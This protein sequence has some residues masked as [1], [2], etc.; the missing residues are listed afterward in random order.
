[1]EKHIDRDVLEHERSLCRQR[2]EA[3]DL[4]AFEP[5]PT[6]LAND[7]RPVKHAR[8]D[9]LEDHVGWGSLAQHADALFP[10]QDSTPS[11]PITLELDYE[12]DVE[13]KPRRHRFAKPNT[14]WNTWYM[15][16]QTIVKRKKENRLS[17]LKYA[18][19][20]QTSK[21]VFRVPP[22]P[23]YSLDVDRNHNCF[24]PG[25]LGFK[26]FHPPLRR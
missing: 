12:S 8:K 10:S 1:M 20:D 6:A 18:R 15:R 23:C 25:L 9:I 2:I 16:K 14:E 24:R 26:A 5:D 13:N 21:M 4:L 19:N 7:I 17:N 3:E 11:K 22:I